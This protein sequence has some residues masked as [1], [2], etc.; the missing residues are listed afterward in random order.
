MNIKVL[1][2]ILAAGFCVVL[3]TQAVQA[4]GN[5]QEGKKKFYTCGGCH[6]IE[7]YSN[8]YPNYHVP[9]LG[10]QKQNAVLS[11]LQAYKAGDRKHG[12]QPQNNSMQ[13]NADGWSEGDLADISAYVAIRK[14]STESNVIT[15]NPSKGKEKTSMCA[16]CHGDD[17]NVLDKDGKPLN[18]ES[19]RLAGQYEDYLINALKGYKKG[20]RKNPIM[21][22]MAEM[23]SEDEIK[24]ISAFYASQKGLT[25][26]SD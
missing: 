3:T 25:T 16:G 5:E 17:G 4:A 6:S 24:D 19:P 11:A 21:N 22:G 10:G 8:A 7:G 9:R 20:V 15:G 13:G 2:S 23:L 12:S 14:L 26:I 18:E 1:W